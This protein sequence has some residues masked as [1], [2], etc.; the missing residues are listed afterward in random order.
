MWSE[1]LARVSDV[2]AFGEGVAEDG[3]EVLDRAVA[4]EGEGDWA[5]VVLPHVLALEVDLAP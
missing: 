4:L 2:D 3:H 5:E 1:G